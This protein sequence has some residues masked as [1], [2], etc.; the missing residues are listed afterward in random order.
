MIKISRSILFDSLRG[1][2]KTTKLSSFASYSTAS[3]AKTALYDLH[4]KHG[5]KMVVFA[6]HLMPILYK[7][8]TIIE[9][10]LHTR[11]SASIFDVSHMLQTSVSGR[12]PVNASIRDK[13]RT[14]HYPEFKPNE[15][16]LNV[17]HKTAG[18]DAVEFM[19]SLTVADVR[20]LPA[21]QSTLS[22]FTNANGGIVDD[23]IITKTENNSDLYVVSNAG[24]IEKDKRLM[25]AKLSELQRQGK[26][27]QLAYLNGEFSLIALQGPKAAAS[28][29]T[30]V[31]YDLKSQYF[32]HSKLSQILDSE[33]R[34][35]R[36]GY[37]GEDGFEISI[38]NDK[39]ND[40]VNCL[41]SEFQLAALFRLQLSH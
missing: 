38:R 15:L 39:V 12:K 41:L 31:N 28:L 36:C 1:A 22:L 34:I 10:H 17:L 7:D 21:N 35:T 26:D 23:L 27:V 11:S 40:L 3:A 25:E 37:T 5:A 14:T 2:R 8:N 29:Q 13:V 20:N 32:M 30:L 4:L 18:K 9:S 6:D 24:C 19:E 33:V 16:Q